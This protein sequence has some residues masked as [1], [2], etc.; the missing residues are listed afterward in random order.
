M[1]N[2]EIS[3]QNPS[4]FLF[5]I[6]QS[7][8]MSDSNETGKSLSE[9]VADIIN[10]LLQDLLIKC[11]KSEGIRDYFD[12]GVIAYGNDSV[13]NG[14][15]GV[16]SSQ[17]LNKV[18]LIENN[19]LLIE[20]RVKKMSDGAGGIVEQ[21]IKFPIW[22]KPVANGSTPMYRA[23]ETAAKTLI[24]WCEK[25]QNSFPPILINITDGESTDGDPEEIAQQIQRIS[26]NDGGVL[27]FNAH[28][29]SSNKKE[30][31][32][33]FDESILPNENARKLFRM[34]SLLTPQMQE[35]A[36]SFGLNITSESRGYC[37]NTEISSLISFLDI[38]TRASNLR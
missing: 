30:Y 1:F 27:V 26:T 38:G 2:A 23:F 21:S 9:Q 24:D 36:K 11:S 14:F 4:A 25:N 22:F 32:F 7:G 15:S 29:T 35:N 37:Y 34:S 16:L 33:A 31:L 17:M 8:S 10:R 6:D 28:I 13:N 12:V 20:N 19:P 5:M 3:R 18:S